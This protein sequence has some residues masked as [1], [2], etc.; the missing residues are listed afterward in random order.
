MHLSWGQP[1]ILCLKSHLPAH[2]F[3]AVPEVYTYIGKTKKYIWFLCFAREDLPS[4]Q[5]NW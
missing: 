3:N 5:A 1:W 2:I 4:F